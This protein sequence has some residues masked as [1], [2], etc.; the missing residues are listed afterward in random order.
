MTRNKV[1]FRSSLIKKMH[2]VEVKMCRFKRF[3]W[4]DTKTYIIPHVQ[5]SDRARKGEG[6][7]NEVS[8]G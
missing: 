7:G 6:Y 8:L 2:K 5:R 3:L 1:F 4:G